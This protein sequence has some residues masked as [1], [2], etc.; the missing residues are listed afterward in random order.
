MKLKKIRNRIMMS[1][2]LMLIVGMISVVSAAQVRTTNW[3]QVPNLTT[4][5]TP[6]NTAVSSGSSS[7]TLK[8]QGAAGDWTPMLFPSSEYVNELTETWYANENLS[9]TKGFQNV[10][11]GCAA[12]YSMTIPRTWSPGPHI[13]TV[14]NP[15][16]TA[17]N[18]PEHSLDLGLAK[19]T[20]R[21]VSAT[22]V[23]VKFYN[24]SVSGTPLTEGVFT[25]KPI[26]YQPDGN[27]GINLR[28]PTGIDGLVHLAAILDQSNNPGTAGYEP[29]SFVNSLRVNGNIYP[30]PGSYNYWQY[31]VYKS[32][33]TLRPISERI[34]AGAMKLNSNDKLIWVCAPYG[35]N[36]PNTIS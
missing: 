3:N 2:I 35:Y 26:D 29:N 30:G 21:N 6:F 16:Y 9:L 11:S 5:Q 1:C 13:L 34:G 10:G 7:V 14:K 24:N 20:N 31:R 23:S 33:G 18:A 25:V 12:T 22:N 28:Y 4:Y 27:P 36:F 15:L 8:V 32:N 17:A 19:D